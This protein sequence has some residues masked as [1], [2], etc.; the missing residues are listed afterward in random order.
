MFLYAYDEGTRES[1]GDR[2]GTTTNIYALKFK[3]ILYVTVT[4][5]SRIMGINLGTSQSTIAWK[6]W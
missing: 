5:M 1:V 2:K 3:I 4:W 6:I